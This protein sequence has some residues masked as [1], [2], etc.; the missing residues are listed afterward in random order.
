MS[1][2]R[3]QVC[4]CGFVV[5]FYVHKICWE[6]TPFFSS[7]NG[8]TMNATDVPRKKKWQSTTTTFS[9]EQCHLPHKLLQSHSLSTMEFMP[10]ERGNL[11]K[12]GRTFRAGPWPHSPTVAAT[13]CQRPLVA[14]QGWMQSTRWNGCQK[15]ASKKN[16]WYKEKWIK[17]SDPWGF[18]CPMAKY[19]DRIKLKNFPDGLVLKNPLKWQPAFASIML[20]SKDLGKLRY[21]NLDMGLSVLWSFLAQA[22]LLWFSLRTHLPHLIHVSIPHM[23][24]REPHGS[25]DRNSSSALVA[26]AG[27]FHIFWPSSRDK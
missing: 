4:V 14:K 19:L 18:S 11:V 12:P 23:L 22:H 15:R 25:K 26:I 20:R 27:I 21:F 9:T 3:W 6:L 8:D 24:S 7:G 16:C 10:L 2:L 5:C 1:I 13:P 17:N